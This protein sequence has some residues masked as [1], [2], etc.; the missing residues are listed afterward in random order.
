[1][2]A[3]IAFAGSDVFDENHKDA[4]KTDRSLCRKADVSLSDSALTLATLTPAEV[5]HYAKRHTK[6]EGRLLT[7]VSRHEPRLGQGEL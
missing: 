1:M 3:L 6:G 5:S 7:G 4:A 2:V